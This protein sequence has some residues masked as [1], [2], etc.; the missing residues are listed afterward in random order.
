MLCVFTQQEK[1]P[2]QLLGKSLFNFV[3][4]VF[5]SQWRNPVMISTMTGH[6]RW[7]KP[8]RDYMRG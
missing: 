8:M 3:L 4:F 2:E 6:T 1:T 7:V 5:S